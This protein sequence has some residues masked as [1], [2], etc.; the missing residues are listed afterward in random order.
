MNFKKFLQGTK[1]RHFSKIS[2]PPRQSCRFLAAVT[3]ILKHV[4]KLSVDLDR[5]QVIVNYYLLGVSNV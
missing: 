3:E 1:T 4:Q 2:H 5:E